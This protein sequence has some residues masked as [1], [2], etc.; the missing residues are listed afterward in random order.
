[1]KRSIVLAGLV[2][3]VL[4]ASPTLAHTL[5]DISYEEIYY[6]ATNNC[7]NRPP[8]RM[9]EQH[10]EMIRLMIQIEKTFNVPAQMRGMLVAAACSESGYNPAAQG[11]WRN[12]N[13]R[14]RVRRVA[15]AI[16]ILQQWP[17][18]ERHYN[19]NR[20]NP[21]Q[22]ADSWMKH[23]VRQLPSVRKRCR[24]SRHNERKLWVAAWV[25][26][27][28]APKVGGRCNERPL[29]YRVLRRWH[30]DTLRLR[31]AELRRLELQGEEPTQY[32]PGC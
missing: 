15:M 11:D 29:H 4:F 5:P 10:R 16:G 21:A 8:A 27:I 17:W 25:H 22:A 20:L 12:R 30:R 6:Q 2:V 24:I 9:T 13:R 31:R 1:M 14:N 28:R 32:T 23:I 3:S 7:H 26:A 19:I 18:Y